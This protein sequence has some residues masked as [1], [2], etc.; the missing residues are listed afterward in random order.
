MRAIKLNIA[1]KNW[2]YKKDRP[3]LPSIE[4]SI[5]DSINRNNMLLKLWIEFNFDGINRQFI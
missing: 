1:L 3:P 4:F 2:I 5:L